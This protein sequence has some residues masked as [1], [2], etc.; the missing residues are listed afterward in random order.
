M[1]LVQIPLFVYGTLRSYGPNAHLIT[2]YAIKRQRA[3]VRGALHRVDYTD[4]E[5]GPASTVSYWAEGSSR[6]EGDLVHLAPHAELNLLAQLDRKELFF[7]HAS[8]AGCVFVRQIVL[9][10][11]D[12]QPARAAWT[13]VVVPADSQ[14]RDCLPPD[15]DGVVRYRP[16]QR[17]FSRLSFHR[18]LECQA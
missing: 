14:T 13:Y 7:D 9:V 15:D 11:P 2:P 1:L 10:T 18:E 8:S 16:T 5:G 17:G 12:G 3:E 4:E 6:I